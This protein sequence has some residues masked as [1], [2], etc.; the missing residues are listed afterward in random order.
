M[1]SLA[2]PSRSSPRDAVRFIR[3][4]DRRLER[5]DRAI[6]VADWDLQVGRSKEGSARW[7]LK[8][9]RFLSDERLLDW[10]RSAQ[11]K[12]WPFPVRR[13][14]ELL[15]RVLLDTQVEQHPE[16]VRLRSDLQRKIITY[17]PLWKG[18]R[19]GRSVLYRVMQESPRESE[20]KRAFYAYESL[21]RPI[22]GP[23]QQLIEL[24]NQR[25]RALGYRSMAEMRLGFD[26]LTPRRLR[27]FADRAAELARGRLRTLRETFRA[28]TGQ[29]SW[30]PWDFLY[31][32]HRR[33]PLPARWFPRSEM[34]PR[35]LAAVSKW[36][37]RTER[38][39][40]RVVFHDTPFGGLTLAPDPPRDVRILIHPQGGWTSYMIM[41][42]EVGHAVHSS[43]I[44]AP[45]HLLRWSENVP[46]FGPF[47][48]GIGGL[49]EEIPNGI[50]WLSTQ[51]RVD[52]ARAEEF[53][54]EQ[55]DGNLIW[56]AWHACWFRAEEL[57]YER[58]ERDPMPEVER[59]ERR[60][61]GFDPYRPH[62]FVD[63]F[64]V[65]SPLYAPNYLLAILF[66]CQV[67]RA[68]RSLF[69]EPLWP[70]RKVGPWLARNWFAPGSLYDWVPRMKE[71]TGRP[72][73]T[74][75]FRS[76]FA[77]MASG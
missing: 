22:E 38:M 47:H 73:G 9:A 27:E 49:F 37:F 19:V 48:E 57:L 74:E 44:R 33:A 4:L 61:F 46:G 15:E 14:L 66:G 60:V 53:A 7:Q 24:R 77:A 13:R 72:F 8:R 18:K 11:R 51:P 2:L 40:F 67:S 20:R 32:R 16:V 41:F 56:A 36:G 62:S 26:G 76:E 35:I 28:E 5:L 55:R 17:R 39:R 30:G 64:F 34:M 6:L 23:L 45:R 69:G 43:L 31:A 12:S 63:T 59:L 75:A 65:D 29:S 25:A 3:E 42:H 21:H 50:E 10:V 54:R 58:P 1:A 70:N 71:I 52:A 68:L